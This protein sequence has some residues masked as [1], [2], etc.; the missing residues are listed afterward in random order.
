MRKIAWGILGTGRIAGN[1]AADLALLPDAELVAVG[2]RS[3]ATA[4]SFAGRFGAPHAHG[5]YE[6]LAA[7]PAVEVIYIATPHPLHAENMKLCLRAGKAVLCEKPFTL[8]AREAEE[9]IA[10]AREQKLFLMEAMW[11]RFLPAVVRA[12]EL[13]EQGAIGEVRLLLADFGFR[14]AFD[15]HHRLFDP[16]LGGGALLD[17]GVYCVSLASMLFGPPDPHGEPGPPWPY[18]C[19]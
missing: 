11:T 6:A 12:R 2:S 15:P 4:Q 5:S 14:A 18:G 10:L 1:F 16:Q 3:E 13:I 19:G 8:N 7:D 17:L 9:V